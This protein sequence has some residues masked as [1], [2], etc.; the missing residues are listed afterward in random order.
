MEET[1]EI[2]SILANTQTRRIINL[3]SDGELTIHQISNLLSLSSSTTYR[4]IRQLEELKIIKKTKVVQTLE[5]VAESYYKNWTYKITVTFVDGEISYTLE[6]I[7]LEDKI[8]RLWQKF[9][10]K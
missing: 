4:K 6:H 7:K 10:K 1:E 3:I 2:L 9:G 8:V 5:G